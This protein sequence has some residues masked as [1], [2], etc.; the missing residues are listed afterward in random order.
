M[1]VPIF[2]EAFRASEYGTFHLNQG[3]ALLMVGF[4]GGFIFW[5]PLY[6]WV[7]AFAYVITWTV[8]VIRAANKEMKPLPIIGGIKIM[9]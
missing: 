3:L 6:G 5:I 9:N 4:V 2:D 8:G 1:L 7:A